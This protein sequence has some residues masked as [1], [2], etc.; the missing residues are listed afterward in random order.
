MKHK[1]VIIAYATVLLV[2]FATASAAAQHGQT[3]RPM[4][5]GNYDTK[6]EI[7]IKGTV[8]KVERLG[9]DHTRGMAGIHLVVKTA[10]ETFNVHLGPAAFVEET[11]TFKKGD[12]VEVTGAK[13]AIMGEMAV[14]ARE[15]KKGDTTLKLR[16]EHGMPLWRMHVR[17]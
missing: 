13:M 2:G 9:S 14:I 8:E 7:T 5:S 10:N 11:M 17:G 6:A 16:D 4:I 1:T 3:T 15:V 12:A